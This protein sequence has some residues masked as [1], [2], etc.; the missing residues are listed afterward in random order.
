LVKV[1]GFHSSSNKLV[2]RWREGRYGHMIISALKDNNENGIII[3]EGWIPQEYN[4]E[5]SNF[6]KNVT[7]TGILRK[8][9]VKDYLN[10]KY[11]KEKLKGY[12]SFINMQ[13]YLNEF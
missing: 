13:E 8:A 5:E 2:S 3:N 7:I 11:E 10:V 6:D 12:E 1:S 4:Y 9:E